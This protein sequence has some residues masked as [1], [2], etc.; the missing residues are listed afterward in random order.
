MTTAGDGFP[1]DLQTVTI[2]PQP[3]APTGLSATA[4]EA[5]VTL[6]WDDPDNL[7]INRYQL[8]QKSETKLAA[9]D[10]AANTLFGRSVAMDG[11]TLV[12]GAPLDDSNGVDSGAAYVFTR[13]SSGSWRQAVKLV[14]SDGAADNY[15][16]HTV[17]VDGDTVVVGVYRD[18][19]EAG[20]VYVFTKPAGG[21]TTGATETAKLT[22]SDGAAGDRF[23]ISVAVN[24][25][26]VVVGAYL[27]SQ[28]VAYSGSAYVFTRDSSGV[29]RQT[30][31]LAASDGESGDYF[32][33]SVAVDGDTVMVGAWLDDVG[34]AKPDS[35]S[36]YV[37][38]KP[39]GGWTTGTEADKLTASDGA[40]GATGSES[41]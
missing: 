27:G 40:A 15:F 7:T 34:S 2:L 39:A 14:A 21:W 18:S 20:S 29:W 22:A 32:G 24:G 1:S 38:T 37:F 13:D 17:A 31:K 35:G 3:A 19:E 41:R 9:S 23:G 33:Y 10:I 6:S 16:G 4:G 25:D 12:I 11:D 8:L 26:T 5:Q 28:N 36:V 30:A